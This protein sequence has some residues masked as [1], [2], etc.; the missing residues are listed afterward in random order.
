[1]VRAN[2][3][4]GDL[5]YHPQEGKAVLIVDARATGAQRDALASFARSMSGNLIHNVVEVKSSPIAA[6]IGTCAKSGCAKVKAGNLVEISTR[7]LGGK[8]HVCGNE[9]AFYPPLTQVTDAMPAYTELASFQGDGL[10]LT[11]E[12]TGQRSAFLAAF[13]R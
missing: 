11:W 7:C 2:G 13:S 6:E 5:H 3:T 8:D 4:L 1:V 12:S 10:G 9:T